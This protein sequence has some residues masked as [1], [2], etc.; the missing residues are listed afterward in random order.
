[1]LWGKILKVA[2]I[3]TM[4]PKPAAKRPFLVKGVGI[5]RGERA[6]IYTIPNHKNPR[7]PYEKGITESE[8]EEAYRQLRSTGQL[9]HKW[10]KVHMSDCYGEGSCNF[11]T[12]GGLFELVGWAIYKERGIYI[13]S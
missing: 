5:R 10:F 13:K 8:F 12:V 7:S 6:L 4:I 11:T 9:S 2:P 1:M 3:G